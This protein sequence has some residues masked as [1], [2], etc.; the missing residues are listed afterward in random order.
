MPRR[1]TPGR[2]KKE[3]KMF[4]LRDASKVQFKGKPKPKPNGVKARGQ[5][6]RREF[7]RTQG[8]KYSLRDYFTSREDSEDNLEFPGD[9]TSGAREDK[10]VQ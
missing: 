9:D 3:W 1:R 8:I 10:G 2:G 5:P 4:G 7:D 6:S